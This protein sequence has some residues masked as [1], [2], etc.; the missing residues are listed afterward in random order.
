M[1]VQNARHLL[2]CHD[3]RSRGLLA[4]LEVIR[5][6]ALEGA[7]LRLELIEGVPLDTIGLDSA[8]V[9]LWERFNQ[10]LISI[11]ERLTGDGIKVDLLGDPPPP[12]SKTYRSVY[13]DLPD[14]LIQRH[15]GQSST[16]NIG[17]ESLNILYTPARNAFVLID[18]Y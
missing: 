9:K 12:D 2:A 8:G 7:R 13:F 5:I 11:H 3:L 15:L 16:V 17:I 1:A 10:L 18:P 14:I 4:D 6:I